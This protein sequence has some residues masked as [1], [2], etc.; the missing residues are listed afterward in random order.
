MAELSCHVE[1]LTIE[2]AAQRADAAEDGVDGGG[3]KKC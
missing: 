1:G 3:G 2:E